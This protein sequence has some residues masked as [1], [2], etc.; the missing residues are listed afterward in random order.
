MELTGDLDNAVAE[1]VAFD[2][3]PA[4]TE[5]LGSENAAEI[6]QNLMG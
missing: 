3:E 1:D 5:E 2:A 6:I 4:I